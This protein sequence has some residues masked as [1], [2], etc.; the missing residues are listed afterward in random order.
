MENTPLP[1]YVHEIS[2]FIKKIVANKRKE[3]SA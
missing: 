3:E 2:A 1:F